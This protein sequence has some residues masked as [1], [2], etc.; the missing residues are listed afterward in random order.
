LGNLDREKVYGSA[1]RKRKWIHRETRGNAYY[2]K[3]LDETCE[4][5][6][7]SNAAM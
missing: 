5:K 3:V 4:Q 7:V 6:N 2:F 1:N